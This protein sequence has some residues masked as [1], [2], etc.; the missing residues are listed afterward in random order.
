MRHLVNIKPA[1][2]STLYTGPMKP[3]PPHTAMQQLAV[4]ALSALTALS[5]S[6]SPP[7]LALPPNKKA[8]TPDELVQIVKADFTDRKYLV[9]G[10]LTK[11]VY[12]DHCHFADERDDFGDIGLD[13]W[14]GAVNFLFI[15]E[16]SKLALTGPVEYDEA[17]RTITFT[18]W[19]QVDVFRLPGSP[20]TP[21]FTGHTVLTL[22]PVDNIIIDHKESW[23]SA[24]DEVS[25]KIK[26]FD[27]SFDPPGFSS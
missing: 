7:A 1:T 17:K 11:E 10:Q 9:T 21:V 25:S 5:I 12:S 24:P 18:G 8:V 16:K 2:A 23:D 14:A 20:H 22:D 6:F 13:R 15:G 3:Q 19:R 27:D 26:F 4:S